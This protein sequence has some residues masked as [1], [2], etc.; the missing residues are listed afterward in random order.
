MRDGYTRELALRLAQVLGVAMKCSSSSWI[1]DHAACLT[2]DLF[3][4]CIH[5]VICTHAKELCII[6]SM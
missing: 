1:N 2:R 5:Y 4:I 6:N 3:I